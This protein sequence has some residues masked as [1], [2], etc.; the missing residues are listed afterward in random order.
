[1][2]NYSCTLIDY[3]QGNTV[4]AVL[5]I[6]QDFECFILMI[7]KGIYKGTYHGLFHKNA[8]NQYSLEP[9]DINEQ[10]SCLIEGSFSQ[11]SLK[12]KNFLEGMLLFGGHNRE[13]TSLIIRGTVK[14]LSGF[15]RMFFK[16]NK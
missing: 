8:P 15:S 7:K 5:E 11:S 1:M 4:S 10:K 6:A 12:G 3:T 13:E 16:R 2:A 9:L 14:P